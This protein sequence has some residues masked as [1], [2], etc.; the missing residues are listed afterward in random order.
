MFCLFGDL[1]LLHLLV[2][3]NIVKIH[4]LIFVD[5]SVP[6]SKLIY[7]SINASCYNV[8]SKHCF[9]SSPQTPILTCLFSFTSECPLLSFRFPTLWHNHYWESRHL[10]TNYLGIFKM[11]HKHFPFQ[12]WGT[13][14]CDMQSLSLL[15]LINIYFMFLGINLS[16]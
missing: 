15:K 16:R 12:C 6:L 2:S 1:L 3:Q 4:F 7:F 13:E 9:G 8:P 14:A 10:T 5:W 11:M